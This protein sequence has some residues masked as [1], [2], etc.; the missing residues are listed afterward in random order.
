MN[1]LI[2]IVD[3]IVLIADLVRYN[4]GIIGLSNTIAFN[5]PL[6]CIEYLQTDT[7]PAVVIS[8]FQMP[9]MNGVELLNTLKKE[10]TEIS[11]I[12]MTSDP[13]AAASVQHQYPIIEKENSNFFFELLSRVSDSLGRV[14]APYDHKIALPD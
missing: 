2:F 5:N 9:Q 10:H 8:D 1:D 11:G 4:L 12:I 7:I 3:D 13:A 14:Y 6:S